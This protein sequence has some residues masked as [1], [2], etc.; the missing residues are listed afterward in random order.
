MKIIVVALDET[1]KRGKHKLMISCII[2][3]K[4]TNSDW[5]LPTP[6]S[7]IAWWNI[8]GH[9]LARTSTRASYTGP[10]RNFFD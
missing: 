2:N 9:C 3:L 7:T 10:S 8:F 6:P 4:G 1:R 5:I